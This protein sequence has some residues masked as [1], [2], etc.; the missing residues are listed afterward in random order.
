LWGQLALGD[1]R[2]PITSNPIEKLELMLLLS[3]RAPFFLRRLILLQARRAL[4]HIS[5][6][7]FP[8]S[9]WETLRA[10]T[11]RLWH[12]LYH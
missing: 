7:S 1:R 4:E 2:A 8:R 10:S 9:E 12:E 5:K 3:K 6:S 11:V